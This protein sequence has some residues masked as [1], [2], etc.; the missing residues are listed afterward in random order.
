MDPI[1]NTNLNADYPKDL[2]KPLEIE[3]DPCQLTRRVLTVFGVNIATLAFGMAVGASFSLLEIGVTLAVGTALGGILGLIAGIVLSIL[4]INY[5]RTP[6]QKYRIQTLDQMEENLAK[7]TTQD[8]KKK[9]ADLKQSIRKTRA[10]FSEGFAALDPIEHYTLHNVV[11]D[12]TSQMKR[13]PHLKKVWT[14]FIDRTHDLDATYLDGTK[15]KVD[16]SLQQERLVGNKIEVEVNKLDPTNNKDVQQLIPLMQECFS[17]YGTPDLNHLQSGLT[18]FGK[19]RIKPDECLVA[20]RKDS[21]EILGMLMF[22]HVAAD[23]LHIVDIGRKADATKL[24][25]GTLLFENFLRVHS[26]KKISLNVREHNADAINLYQKWFFKVTHRSPSYY[27]YPIEDALTMQFDN[28]AFYKA[29]QEA[30]AE[31]V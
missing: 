14:T 24:G 8:D 13:Q 15:I 22:R 19:G 1:D 27:E 9:L 10:L 23:H 4:I 7:A 28:E 29:Q 18:T 12:I 26:D 3:K 21:K 2:V 20:R 5:E 11:T 30:E 6:E 17:N 25:I 31:A 16:F